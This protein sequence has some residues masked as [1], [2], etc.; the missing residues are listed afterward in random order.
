MYSHILS[1]RLLSLI[2]C[3]V[4]VKVN[5]YRACYNEWQYSTVLQKETDGTDLLS[6]TVHCGRLCTSCLE[7]PFIAVRLKNKCV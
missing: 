1:D 5:W 3:N 2:I 6:S 7:Y 4:D